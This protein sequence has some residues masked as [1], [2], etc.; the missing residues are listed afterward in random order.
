MAQKGIEKIQRIR[1]KIM[2]RNNGRRSKEDPQK[3]IEMEITTNR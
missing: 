2:G 1:N 3:M